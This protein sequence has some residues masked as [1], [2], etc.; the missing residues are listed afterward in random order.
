NLN[1]LVLASQVYPYVAARVSDR[2]RLRPSSAIT[3][4]AMP[5]VSKL[6]PTIR[7]RTQVVLT[8]QPKMMIAARTRSAMPL[9]SIQPH[10]V[11]TTSRYVNDATIWKMPS[12]MKNAVSTIVSDTAPWVGFQINKIPT[13]IDKAAVSS[14][15]RNAGTSRAE[16]KPMSPTKPLIRNNQPTYMS[17]AMVATYGSAMAST[18]RMIITTPWNRNSPQF[19]RSAPL[20]AFCISVRS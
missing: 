13:A 2:A 20:M 19:A 11:G 15:H 8:G 14:V 12:A 18:P 17:T 7:P 3:T 5:E 9:A 1:P 16:N 4:M 6:I 10:E